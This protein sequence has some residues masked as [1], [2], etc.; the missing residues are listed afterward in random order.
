MF[1]R[2]NKE[3]T[4]DN[5]THA[6][7]SVVEVDK[8]RRKTLVERGHAVDVP[9][10]DAVGESKPEPVAREIKIEKTVRRQ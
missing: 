3:I 7:G 5:V 1:I 8:A 2:V 6:A 4:V 9:G 10:P